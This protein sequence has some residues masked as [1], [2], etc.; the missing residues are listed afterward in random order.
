MAMLAVIAM[1]VWAA[2][3]QSQNLWLNRRF[4]VALTVLALI[5]PVVAYALGCTI[6]GSPAPSD[7][8][9][10][11]LARLGGAVAWAGK[12]SEESS[13]IGI[14]AQRLLIR[15]SLNPVACMAP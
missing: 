5:G 3:A 12:S 4:Q 13:N 7:L 1:M 11:V 6:R 2:Q 9:R 14:T 15:Q 8:I 10:A